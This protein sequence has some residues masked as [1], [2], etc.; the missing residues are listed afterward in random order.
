MIL[1]VLLLSSLLIWLDN[2]ILGTA[3]ETLADPVRGLGAGP[4][5]LQWATG[6]YTLVS[7][8]LMFTAGA[9]GDRFGH[10]TVLVGGLVIFAL[11]SVWAAYAGGPG[12]LIAARAVMGVGSAL[13]MP[14]TM[15]ILTWTFTGPARAA[16]IGLFSTSAGVGLAAG[17]LLAGVLLDNFWWGSVFLVN[18]PVVAVGLAGIAWLVPNFRSP[19]RR[20]LDLPGLTLSMGGLAALA[21]GLIR[22]GQ[23]AS[24][25]PVSVWAPIVA[26]LLLLAGFILVELRSAQPS[27]DPRLLAQRIFGGG[28]AA[29]GLLFLA[30]TAAGFCNAFY[31]QGTRGFSPLQAGLATAPAALGV[32]VGGPL[33]VRLVR[34][35]GLRPVSATALAVSATAMGAFVFIGLDTPL[36]WIEIAIAVQG[37]AT[38][39][40]IGPVTAA[41]MSTLPLERAGAGSAVTNTVRQTGSVLGIAIGGTLMS[42]VYRRAIDGSLVDLPP[43]VRE[44]AQVSA[45][46]ARHA[47][48]TAN[49]PGL[50]HAADAAFV[51]AMHVGSVWVMLFALLGAAVLAVTAGPGRKPAEQQ[52]LPQ[53][54]VPAETDAEP[55]RALA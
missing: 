23:V 8:A 55:A 13:I 3:L 24:W 34:R 50:A 30:M 52:Q 39:M 40:V 5:Q 45:E 20:P 46:L 31:L 42:I 14:P 9:L 6:A 17:P 28:N 54:R 43:A 18:I 37:F 10:R 48:T 4:S 1:A 29:L 36:L 7:A 2:T 41:L 27:F 19:A 44:Q 15:A 51:H 11:A 38:G 33:G 26:G 49:R 35:F 32:I 21:Y 47:A 53:Q 22:A 12:E 16:A 25:T